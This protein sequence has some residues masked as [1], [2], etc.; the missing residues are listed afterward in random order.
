MKS[1]SS[2]FDPGIPAKELLCPKG[3]SLGRRFYFGFDD[4][5]NLLS[6][7][8]LACVVAVEAYTLDWITDAFRERSNESETATFAFPI[9][10]TRLRSVEKDLE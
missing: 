10:F 3:L 4:L 6:V 7:N 1:G 5:C 8:R 9:R 2:I